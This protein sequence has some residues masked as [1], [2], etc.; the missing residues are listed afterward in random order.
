MAACGVDAAVEEQRQEMAKC[1]T[2]PCPNT[3]SGEEPGVIEAREGAKIEDEIR[4]DPNDKERWS[5]LILFSSSIEKRQLSIPI[6]MG[7]N[8]N[9]GLNPKKGILTFSSPQASQSFKRKR[10]EKECS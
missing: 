1:T 10:N 4:N 7:A 3:K 9:M 5:S 2:H 8:F 6:V